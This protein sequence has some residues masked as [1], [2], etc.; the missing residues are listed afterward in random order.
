MLPKSNVSISELDELKL[1]YFEILDGN[2]FDSK[3]N[4]YIKHFSDRD[5]S[6]VLKKR[7]ELFYYYLSEGVPHELDLLKR[8]IDNGEWSQDQEDNILSLKYQIS[9][10]ESNIHNIIPQQRGGIEAAIQRTREQLAEASFER[11]QI[12]G[13]SIEDLVDED[14]NDYVIYISFFK[15]KELTKHIEPTY[16]DFQAYES[17]KINALNTALGFHY[18]RISEEKLKGVSCLPMFLNKL[19]FSKDNVSSFLG[20]PIINFTHNQHYIFSF[21]LRNLN[22]INNAKGNP[23]DLNLDAKMHDV[24]KWYD[25]QHSI[26]IGKRNSED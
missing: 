22:I 11:K 24:V 20:K 10:N 19:N 2:S 16:E 8:A 4:F 3:V 14:G 15:D 13:R 21:G 12:L 26:N 5:S 1:I 23:P 25:L 7:E 17:E 18:K 6:L 9:D